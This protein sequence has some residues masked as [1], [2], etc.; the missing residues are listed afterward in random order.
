MSQLMMKTASLAIQLRGLHDKMEA[1]NAQILNRLNDMESSVTEQLRGSC[2]GDQNVGHMA[3]NYGA[4][5]GG[6]GDHNRG[7][8][9]RNEGHGDYYG[10]HE[11]RNKGHG[12]QYD[13]HD[14]R[15]GGYGDQY[16]FH[17]T[18]DGNHNGDRNSQHSTQREPR[19]QRITKN[20]EINRDTNLENMNIECDVGSDCI[21]VGRG[22]N[23]TLYN[24]QVTPSREGR[25]IYMSKGSNLKMTNVYVSGFN[26]VRNTGNTNGGVIFAEEGNH[27]ISITNSNFKYNK[28]RG[29]GS[30]LKVN[31]SSV[32]IMNTRFE[33]NTCGGDITVIGPGLGHGVVNAMRCNIVIKNSHFNSNVGALVLTLSE[34]TVS[35]STFWGNSF[36]EYES[37]GAAMNIFDSNVNI[38]DCKFKSNKAKYGG[39]IW[40]GT[41]SGVLNIEGDTQFKGN[42]ATSKAYQGRGNAISCYGARAGS[43]Q[44]N[45]LS[46]DGVP[47]NDIK[48]DCLVRR[49]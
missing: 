14:A 3:S 23:L 26:L 32:E 22:V 47:T 41:N 12:K 39:A 31:D 2:N 18:H 16:A 17:E 45:I 24:V 25:F 48:E 11:A 42:R 10:S 9:A 21:T 37:G 5:S 34:V 43:V 1:G 36:G 20:Y 46:R 29:G 6:Y 30:V 7:H 4:R 19:V 27:H 8:E 13:V 33:N 44:I 35:S 40:M 38:D 49:S 28:I 15:N